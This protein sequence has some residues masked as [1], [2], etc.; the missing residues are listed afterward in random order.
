MPPRVM[1]PRGRGGPLRGGLIWGR[2]ALRSRGAI[3]ENP[4]PVPT[5][6]QQVG[7]DIP[8]G[9]SANS[10]KENVQDNVQDD[11]QNKMNQEVPQV[12]TV[13]PVSAETKLLLKHMATT[14]AGAF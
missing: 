13:P 12:P 5:E 4:L 2:N 7:E 14:M 1:Y 3:G 6:E 8:A 11:A 10:W 9:L